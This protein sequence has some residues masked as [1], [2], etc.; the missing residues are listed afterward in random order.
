MWKLNT[1]Y[2]FFGGCFLGPHVQHMG[3]PRLG[4]ELPLQLQAYTTATATPDPQLTEQ[5]QGSNLQGYWSEFPKT[6]FDITNQP[7]KKLQRKLQNT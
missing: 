5:G 3:V 2:F 7:K 4:A 6:H 1:T